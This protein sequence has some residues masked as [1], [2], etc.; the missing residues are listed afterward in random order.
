MLKKV[1]L[2][3]ILLIALLITSAV[4]LGVL[5]FRA[6][7]STRSEIER[8]QKTQLIARVDA[9][10][11]ALD[12]QL[13]EFENATTYAALQ[14]KNLMLGTTLDDAEVQERLAK[15][16]RDGSNVYGL[17]QWYNT[18]Y[19]PVS[20]DDHV[21]NVFLNPKTE[22]TPELAYTIAATEDL[23][24]LFE[25]IRSSGIGTQWIYLTTKEGL[26][27]RYPWSPDSHYAVDW[28]PQTLNFY[29]AAASEQNPERKPVWTAP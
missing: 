11:S 3:W 21:S 19:F 5:A 26:M 17:D 1:S 23:D 25:A 12:H 8:E 4:P 13:R 2:F 29:T 24:P 10:A 22:L 9:H 7:G 27:R 20:S 18:E 6:R 16:Q 14:A 28:E 15:Y